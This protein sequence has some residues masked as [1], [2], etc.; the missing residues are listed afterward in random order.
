MLK[1]ICFSQFAYNSP[2]Q[3]TKHLWFYLDLN[4]YEA[5][6]VLLLLANH[7]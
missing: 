2:E 6:L 4:D 1:P 7:I 5:L 3:L